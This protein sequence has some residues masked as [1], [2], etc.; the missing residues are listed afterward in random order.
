MFM[1]KRLLAASTLALATLVAPLA[2]AQDKWPD[3]PIHL[4]V[5]WPPGGV[6]DFVARV[7]GQK[8]S[9]NLGQPV[10]VE[11][12]P[13]A[14]TNIGSAYVAQAKPDGYT[15]LLASTSNSV[16]KYIFENMPYD[17]V[18]DFA[19][20]SLLVNVPN[21]LVTAPSTKITSVG[22]LIDDAR[23]HPGQ[24]TY[25]SAGNGSPAHLAAEKFNHAAGIK[26]RKITYKGAAPAVIDVMA[27]RV[28]VMF[29]NLPASLSAIQAKQL[30]ALGMASNAPSPIVPGVPVIAQ[31][32]LK[33]YEASAWYGLLAPAKTPPGV[34]ARLSQAL[35]AIRTPDVMK[36][37]TDRGTEPVISP[38]DVLKAQIQNDIS[39]YGPIIQATG[40]KPE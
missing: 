38:P 32:G 10:I 3:A 21:V 35:A 22:Q 6:A 19:P 25:A 14:G 24:L 12:R 20:V 27:G 5:P 13:G 16:N 36:Q 40:I 9:V 18:K 26:I 23:K 2:H 15:L 34:L 28:S 17:V 7:I 29:T 39:T 1:F 11:N 30:V 4:V 37:L 31:A 33:G 8:L